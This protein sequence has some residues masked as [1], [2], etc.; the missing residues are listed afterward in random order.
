MNYIEYLKNSDIPLVCGYLESK[1]KDTGFLFTFDFRKTEN[2]G[3]PQSKW[4]EHNGK[5]IFDMTVGF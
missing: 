3:K 1:N 5:K 4:V 2:I